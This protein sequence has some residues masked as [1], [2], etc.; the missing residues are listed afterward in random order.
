MGPLQAVLS[1][2]TARVPKRR[3]REQRLGLVLKGTTAAVKGA[4]VGAQW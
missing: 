1:M 2:Q 4:A 3:V